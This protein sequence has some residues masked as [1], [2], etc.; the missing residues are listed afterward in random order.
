MM[1]GLSL[2]VRNKGFFSDL[3]PE[4]ISL[5]HL[6]AVSKKTLLEGFKEAQSLCRPYYLIAIVKIKEPFAGSKSDFYLCEGSHFYL[7]MLVDEK[8]VDA[9]VLIILTPLRQSII[10]C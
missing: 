2:P 3:Y 1:T 6:D 7:H 4:K 8:S 9:A 5:A 10:L